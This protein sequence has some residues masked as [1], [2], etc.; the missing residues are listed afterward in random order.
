MFKSN[1]RQYMHTHLKHLYVKNVFYD[2]KSNNNSNVVASVF[3]TI[4][5]E[6]ET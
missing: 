2:N 1:K 4:S 5:A 3:T 6:L